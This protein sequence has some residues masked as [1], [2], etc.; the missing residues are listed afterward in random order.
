MVENWYN[1]AIKLMLR[2]KLKNFL[3]LHQRNA[4]K[5][6]SIR[7]VL[8]FIARQ[9]RNYLTAGDWRQLHAKID[10]Q[11]VQK[12]ARGEGVIKEQEVSSYH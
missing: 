4:M 12:E 11:R 3:S 5:K 8:A 9:N 10:K 7:P 1:K 6:L 2:R